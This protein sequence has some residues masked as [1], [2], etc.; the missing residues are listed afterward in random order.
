M[1][2]QDKTFC[3]GVPGSAGTIEI[4]TEGLRNILGQVEAELYRSEVYR[5]AMTNLQQA[6][7]EGGASAQFLLKAVGR[8][9]IRLALRH[10]LRHQE[11]DA[12]TSEP[13]PAATVPA[14]PMI[15]ADA[16]PTGAVEVAPGADPGVQT[17]APVG[18]QHPWLTAIGQLKLPKKPSSAELAA[19]AEQQRQEALQALGAQIRQA[20]QARSLSLEGLH[21]KSL[22]P[23]HHL[24]AIE[25]GDV[26]HLPEMIFLRGFIQRIAPIVGLESVQLLATLP[27]TD[28]KEYALPKWD[29]IAGKSERSGAFKGLAGSPLPLYLG[30][31]ALMAGGFAWLSQQTAPKSTLPPIEIDVPRAK[32]APARTTPTAATP[33]KI[34]PK[35][36]TKMLRATQ[37]T[38]SVQPLVRNVAPPETVK[39]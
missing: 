11:T 22:V 6:P 15:V 26:D 5:R 9:A 35:A 34:T 36:V 17:T 28:P 38:K 3:F 31:A 13:A 25:A 30:Y 20:R 8:E 19:A 21:L 4:S 24:K 33:A 16:P 27:A 14:T 29:Y 18:G 2:A 23:I 7:T 32:T 39:F 12:E 10:F 37:A 1:L